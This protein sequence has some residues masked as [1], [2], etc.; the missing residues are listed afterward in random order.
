MRPGNCRPAATSGLL[1]LIVVIS[2]PSY[3]CAEDN[4]QSLAIRA[5][6]GY[7]TFPDEGFL[8]HFV[9]GGA[10]KL[11]ISS[12]LALEPELLYLYHSRADQDFHF[13][14]NVVYELLPNPQR[15]RP[16]L[17]GGAGWQR[18]RELTGTGYYSS[19]SW[20]F[21][22]GVGAR[23]FLTRR[24]YVAPEIRLGWEPFL[25]ATGSIGYVFT[26]K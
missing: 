23:I 9:V 16:Y 14:P 8:H 6:A 4:Q 22:G 21:G 7:A 17:I 1:L 13:I 2:V 10:V 24:L 11:P 3:S 15:I 5:I 26:G 20:T 25:R 12:R 19:S 18:H